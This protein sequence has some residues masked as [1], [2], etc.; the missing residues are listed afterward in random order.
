MIPLSQSTYNGT[1][2][3][4]AHRV[5]S[6]HCVKY[7]HA[8]IIVNMVAGMDNL[9]LLAAQPLPTQFSLCVRVWGGRINQHINCSNFI[10]SLLEWLVIIIITM[11]I[12]HLAL[13]VFVVH[14]QAVSCM[15]VPSDCANVFLLVFP[16]IL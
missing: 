4:S 7:T 1:T 14:E 11:I 5:H 9:S 15:L 12:T 2:L 13:V 3:Y 8:I 10:F 6:H 16:P